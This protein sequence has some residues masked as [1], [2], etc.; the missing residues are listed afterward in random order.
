MFGAASIPR[1]G[2][3]KAEPKRNG[4]AESGNTGRTAGYRLGAECAVDL[5]VLRRPRQRIVRP[6]WAPH[7]DA[8]RRSQGQT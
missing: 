2:P 1:D 8:A 6:V 4:Y 7:I 3:V 5:H